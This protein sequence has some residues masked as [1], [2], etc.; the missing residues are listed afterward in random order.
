L[1][2]ARRAILFAATGL[3]VTA[4]PPRLAA[5][6]DVSK[7]QPYT[8]HRNSSSDP[9]GAN[10]DYRE[11]GPGQI[12]TLLDADG[13]GSVTHLWITI[14]TSHA[15]DFYLKKLVLRMYWDGESEPSVLTTLGD[16]FGKHF[17]DATP[18]SS[19]F[20]S[21][22]ADRAMNC[23]FPMPFRRHA[24]VTVTNEGTVALGNL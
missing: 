10:N 16:F 14:S 1:K 24:R 23:F 13:P 7:M 4:N 2:I 9:T 12:L 18:W 6:I 21:V 5:Q 17:G 8:P 19:Q 15:E 3:I 20:L 22:G 11:I